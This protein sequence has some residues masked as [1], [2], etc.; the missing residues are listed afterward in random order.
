MK[1]VHDETTLT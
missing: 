1:H